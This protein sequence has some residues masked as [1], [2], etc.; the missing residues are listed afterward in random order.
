MPSI[1]NPSTITPGSYLSILRAIH[2]MKRSLMQNSGAIVDYLNTGVLPDRYSAD[3]EIFDAYVQKAL[4]DRYN[5]STAQFNAQSDTALTLTLT[6]VGKLPIIA[7]IP[8]EMGSRLRSGSDLPWQPVPAGAFLATLPGQDRVALLK[9]IQDTS[10][11][12]ARSFAKRAMDSIIT[13][14]FPNVDPASLSAEVRQ[15]IEDLSI[16]MAQHVPSRTN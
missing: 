3:T 1:S 14:E 15:E 5:G 9:I 13:E 2:P 16:E 12:D 11:S 8:S 6:P 4:E 7:T 10:I